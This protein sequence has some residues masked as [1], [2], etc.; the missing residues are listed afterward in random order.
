MSKKDLNILETVF[1]RGCGKQ[2]QRDHGVQK[3]CT[4]NCR[5]RH[6]R[7][8]RRKAPKPLEAMQRILHEDDPMP[9]KPRA[10]SLVE[11]ERRNGS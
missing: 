1:C 6:R 8:H 11:A 5:K 4:A 7:K 2:F 10:D 3:Y 9:I